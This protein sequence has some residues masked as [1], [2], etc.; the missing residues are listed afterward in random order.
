MFNLLP[1][2]PKKQK[3]NGDENLVLHLHSGPSHDPNGSGELIMQDPFPYTPEKKKKE[4]KD[5]NSV[6]NRSPFCRRYL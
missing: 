4:K 5:S 1:C 3:I 6:N 2:V